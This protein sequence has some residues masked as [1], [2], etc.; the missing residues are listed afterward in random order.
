MC[1]AYRI[2]GAEYIYSIV[3]PIFSPAFSFFNIRP[4][5]ILQN[6]FGCDTIRYLGLVVFS[7]FSCIPSMSCSAFLVLTC[8]MSQL[9]FSG[10][11]AQLNETICNVHEVMINIT[12]QK[13]ICLYLYL[14]FQNLTDFRL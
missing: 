12:N 11:I 1:T 3:E 10:L 6:I 13:N 9:V 2:S 14:Y 7:F 4:I 5:Y 8:T